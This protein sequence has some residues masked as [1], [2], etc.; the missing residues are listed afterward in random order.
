M[1]KKQTVDSA[2][3]SRLLLQ[4]VI[5]IED[6]KADSLAKIVTIE[7]S[8]AGLKTRLNSYSIIKISILKIFRTGNLWSNN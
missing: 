1:Q 7:Q 2:N 4:E 3:S 8:S 5:K 6:K